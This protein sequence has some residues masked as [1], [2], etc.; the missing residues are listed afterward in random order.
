MLVFFLLVI[1]QIVK[2]SHFTYAHPVD[3]AIH[4]YLS[5]RPG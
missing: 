2:K 1:T 5:N 3:V 4:V